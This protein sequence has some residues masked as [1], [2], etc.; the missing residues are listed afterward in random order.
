MTT[1]KFA[2]ECHVLIK[3]GS[4]IALEKFITENKVNPNVKF[5]GETLLALA[6]NSQSCEMVKVLLR[7]GAN[8]NLK[9]HARPIT[10]PPLI[11]A[12]QN[13]VINI[14]K[15]LLENG[16]DINLTGFHG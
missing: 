3:T 8:P 13:N 15:T 11:I 7:L 16:A 4:L 10:E 5:R 2:W 14:V 6:I 9:S 1:D 12:V